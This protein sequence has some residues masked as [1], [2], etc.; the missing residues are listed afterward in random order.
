[1]TKFSKFTQIVLMFG[2]ASAAFSTDI[3]W[4]VLKD[5]EQQCQNSGMAREIQLK[6]EVNSPGKYKVLTPDHFCVRIWNNGAYLTLSVSDLINAKLGDQMAQG[7]ISTLLSMECSRETRRKLTTMLHD[8]WKW[9]NDLR[10]VSL[11]EVDPVSKNLPQDSQLVYR[12]I[13]LDYWPFPSRTC[14]KKSTTLCLGMSQQQYNLLASKRG[15]GNSW[16]NEVS[17]L[18]ELWDEKNIE[19]TI[20]HNAI[21]SSLTFQSEDFDVLSKIGGYETAFWRTE[22][23]R[24]ISR[25]SKSTLEPTEPCKTKPSVEFVN[26]N[27]PEAGFTVHNYEDPF[28]RH[29]NLV[30]RPKR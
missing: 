27:N 8:V 16:V 28:G 7:K 29:W 4:E 15:Y 26:T 17:S 6:S 13:R 1:M 25:S 9:A 18:L 12:P 22:R 10:D 21:N 19:P 11:C 14:E 3:Q 5:A 23:L 2:C 20:M 24:T 30:V